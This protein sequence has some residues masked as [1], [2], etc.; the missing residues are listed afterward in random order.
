MLLRC[1]WA[2]QEFYLPQW[3]ARVAVA[4]LRPPLFVKRVEKIDDKIWCLLFHSF[5]CFVSVELLWPRICIRRRKQ[6]PWFHALC[7][8]VTAFHSNTWILFSH[9]VK[10]WAKS[11]VSERCATVFTHGKSRQH[12]PFECG[13]SLSISLNGKTDTW[14]VWIARIFAA[15]KDGAL[16]GG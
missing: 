13:M 12:R 2:R 8:T 14:W 9:H 15:S 16:G 7:C 10:A 1:W 11:I 3:T 5:S 6:S 4:L